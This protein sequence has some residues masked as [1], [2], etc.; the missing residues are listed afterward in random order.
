MAFCLLRG[1]RRCAICHTEASR[2]RSHWLATRSAACSFFF[3][4]GGHLGFL[5]LKSSQSLV[6][7]FFWQTAEQVERVDRLPY[8]DLIIRRLPRVC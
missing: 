7:H 4:L 8:S 2:R 3:L 1:S 6:G 5:W